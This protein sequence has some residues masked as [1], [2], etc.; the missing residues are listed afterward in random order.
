MSKQRPK[1]GPGRPISLPL[2]RLAKLL[3]M[4]RRMAS[5]PMTLDVA[6]ERWQVPKSSL[7][8]W[9]S[10]R[11]PDVAAFLHLC[12]CIGIEPRAELL[13]PPDP[14]EDLERYLTE[15]WLTPRSLAERAV[16]E[17]KRALRGGAGA[18]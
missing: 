15:E 14:G 1:D 11:P 16:E 4:R 9:E 18:A 10:G 12:A 5:D 7:S 2:T 3:R 13:E 6:C 17:I 8:R